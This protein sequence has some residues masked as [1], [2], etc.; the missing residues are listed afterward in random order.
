MIGISSRIGNASLQGLQTSSFSALRCSRL[1]L[2]IGQT[3]ISSSLASTQFLQNQFNE[4]RRQLGLDGK[5][6]DLTRRQTRAFYCIL[7]GHQQDAVFG[8]GQIGLRIAVMVGEW[9]GYAVQ[10]MPFQRTEKTLRVADA[11]Q[12]V[13]PATPL[14]FLGGAGLLRLPQA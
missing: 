8:E 2:Q 3:R 7:L 11:G 5:N 1:P 6:P 9:P 4:G 12:R 10:S 13:E 14:Q